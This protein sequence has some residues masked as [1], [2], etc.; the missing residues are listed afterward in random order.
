MTGR[1]Q[2]NPKQPTGAGHPCGQLPA[3]RAGP[4]IKGSQGDQLQLHP[5]PPLTLQF[6]QGLPAAIGG[7]TK[8]V[9]M[10]AHSSQS[11]AQTMLKGSPG[12]LE[13]QIPITTSMFCKV[14]GQGAVIGASKIVGLSPAE[15]LIKMG[16]GF[17]QTGQQQ[18]PGLRPL[19]ADRFKPGD[20]ALIPVNGKWK[21]AFSSCPQ[22]RPTGHS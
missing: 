14:G 7:G 21:Q 9:D 6:K 19:Q 11:V 3:G 20:L 2:H 18:L 15:G 10:A 17:H 16:M 22:L 4:L 12:P 5:A 1:P 13:H 8:A